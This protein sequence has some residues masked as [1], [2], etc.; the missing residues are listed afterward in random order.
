MLS[1]RGAQI[2][3]R[4]PG[5]V[6]VRPRLMDS[7]GL[8]AFGLM[9]IAFGLCGIWLGWTERGSGFWASVAVVAFFAFG[10]VAIA[11]NQRTSSMTLDRD[12][13]DVVIGFR[14]KKLRYRWTDVGAFATE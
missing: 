14:K 9:F 1:L 3:A 11:M 4:F 8:F 5:P 6:T 7:V 12:G 13:F 2:L 10:S